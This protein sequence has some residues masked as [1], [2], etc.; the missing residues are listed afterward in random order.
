M[1][2]TANREQVFEE[3]K[4]TL[5][6]S[7]KS[8]LFAHVFQ[9]DID[10][11]EAIGFG[12]CFDEFLN[13]TYPSVEIF[14]RLVA[15]DELFRN[16]LSETDKRIFRSEFAAT[17]HTLPPLEFEDLPEFAQKAFDEWLENDFTEEKLAA[18]PDLKLDF[19][20]FLEQALD[21][22]LDR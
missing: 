17:F 4:Q 13:N 1:N 10:L 21:N 15:P 3:F 5:T 19:E 12:A 7:Q 11:T 9:Y 2:L 20:N 14:G 16:N 8:E 18:S 6:D 22:N